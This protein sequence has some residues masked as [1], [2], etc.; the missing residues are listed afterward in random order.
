MGREVPEE[1]RMKDLFIDVKLEACVDGSSFDFLGRKLFSTEFFRQSIGFG[2]TDIDIEVNTSLQPLVS[3]TFKDLYG[4]TIFGGQS[5][6]A[7]DDN[8]SIDYSVLFNWP[9][10]KFLFSF[11]GYL[12]KPVTWVLNLKRTS[13]SF[14]SSDGS[15]ELK[16]EFV[17]NQWGFFADLPYLFLLAA[18]RL[19]KDKLGDSATQEQRARVTSVFDLI[20]IGKQVDVK[21]KDTTKEF[22]GLVKQ[23]GAI[24]TNVSR[25]A[26]ISSV[27]EF[28]ETIDG[29]VNNRP[30]RGFIPLRIPEIDNIPN[31]D[32]K[33]KINQN[34]GDPRG[35]QKMNNLILLSIGFNNN[36][37]GV[38]FSNGLTDFKLNAEQV[39]KGD[40]DPDVTSAKNQILEKIS[41]NLQIIDEEISRRVF[42]TEEKKLEKIT[43]GEIFSQLARDSAFT[44]GSVLDAGLDGYRGSDDRREKR[45]NDRDLIG[46]A[47]PMVINE[48][49]N[50]V[51]A[52]EENG[53]S[54]GADN[55]EMKFV[56]AFIRAIS[57]GIA[58]DLVS[59]NNTIGQER[60]IIKQRINNCEMVLG[61]PYKAFYSSIVTNVLVRSGIVAYMTRSS[62]PNRPGDFGN[63]TFFD[64]DS[65]GEIQQI[66]ERDAQNVTDSTLA[67][68]SSVDALLL[69]RFCDFILKFY[70]SG[71][72]NI[73]D[74]EGE[75]VDEFGDPQANST[76]EVVM[77]ENPDVTLTFKRL[78]EE[79]KKPSTFDD[80]KVIN[81]QLAVNQGLLWD[82]VEF[83]E[84]SGATE[85]NSSEDFSE[86]NQRGV[87]DAQNPLSFVDN[88]FTAVSIMNN[89]IPYMFPE[90]GSGYWMVLFRGQDN[91]KAQEANSAPT[92]AEYK[93]SDKDDPDG[94]AG[95][96]EPL[97]YVPVNS[98][99][100][101]GENY[102]RVEN[103]LD[104]FAPRVLDYDK[105][106]KVNPIFYKEGFNN[107]YFQWV[108]E[109]GS[110][111]AVVE[112]AFD[113]TNTQESDVA[114]NFGYTVAHA[115]SGDGLVFGLFEDTTEGI[116]QR[117]FLRR[118][119]REILR[120]LEN[121][122]DERN[123]VIGSVLGKAGEQEGAL[124]KQMHVLFHQWQALSFT[125][126]QGACG[127][128]NVDE[129]KS[130]EGGENGSVFTIAEALE[131]KFGDSHLNMYLHEKVGE[132]EI[133]SVEVS[134]NGVPD[135]TFIYDFPLQRIR[136]DIAQ[137]QVRDSII[138]L[139][140]LY[141][142]NG[143]T[144]VL[145]IIQ[146]I[147]T[148][149]NFLFVP[150]PGNPDYLGSKNLYSPSPEPANID[151]RNFFHILFTPTPESRTKTRNKDGESLSLNANHSN[152]AA[153]SF[154][155]KYGH[156]DNQIV[157]NISVGTDDTKPTA[158]S[159][160]NLQRLADNEN[161]NKKVTTD[162]S[163]L[164]VLAGRSYKAS[165]DM[166][167]NAQVYPMQFFFLENSPLF[168]GLY[169]VMKVKHSITPNDFKTSVDGIRMRFTPTNGYGSLKPVTLQTF[170]NLGELEAPR[171]LSADFDTAARESLK[172]FEST[173]IEGDNNPVGGYTKDSIERAVKAAG[174]KWFD[175]QGD[176]ELNIVGVR[177]TTTGNAVTNR[178][179]DFITLSYKVN[180]EWKFWSWPATTQPGD[181]YVVDPLVGKG[182]AIL[183]PGQYLDSHK[184]RKHAGSYDAL[185]QNGRVS[186]YRDDNKNLLY[187]TVE[188]TVETGLFGINIHRSSPSGTSSRVN[189]WSAGCQ[190]F[191]N[192]DNFNQ[193]MSICRAAKARHGN[194]FTYTLLL[195][196]NIDT[197]T[198]A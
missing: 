76:Y 105:L 121:I 17:P 122:E 55:H 191:S 126:K 165:I 175:S 68:L 31:F 43:I 7:A 120:K 112:D 95:V 57:E 187:D 168:G 182:V 99:D 91:I 35:L 85:S 93:N 30:I 71:G 178:F 161:Q 33:E 36:L 5:R 14:N 125:E 135:G 140:P 162:C 180:G 90:P 23:L 60:D 150:I 192:I 116:N 179:D 164:P 136:D 128:G 15:Y 22:D 78:W 54:V 145:N 163:M 101:D 18:K 3:V 138:N 184:I 96:E 190:V 185:G 170:R 49:G 115:P 151:V 159:I 50:E 19:R 87:R 81:G 12:G 11:K 62:D 124:Y 113:Q 195:S 143:N 56:R 149:N 160:V 34:L 146:Q 197:G 77:S 66:A 94:T 194:R 67:S 102:G 47:F 69:K 20:K 117:V 172:N 103:L 72:E 155:I 83:V 109:D 148:K 183:K 166:L 65:T 106:K 25:A 75:D 27:V 104:D 89:G 51:P 88:N 144:T 9:P 123:Q 59:D 26:S 100:E 45:D 24:K 79:L 198:S 131:K 133:G 174:H 46:Q 38:T 110:P 6:E 181:D 97:G 152:Y 169:Q 86:T 70:D 196:S 52:I 98:A 154:V 41:K 153:N 134:S 130:G 53:K 186:V 10:P 1:F 142:A 119:C 111:K 63:T 129:F 21:T 4:S 132:V 193:F 177:N 40:N 141:K 42:A 74:Q 173:I 44:I 32:T 118:F 114:G 2:I 156:P 84:T 108:S 13:T 167:G 139:E 171:A 92:D 158:E 137:I 48:E 189:K 8:Q 82:E 39:L 58:R 29:I 28:G 107:P 37:D 61:N 80:V 176:Y 127:G 64:N 16:C 73:I 147:C 157:S 188:S